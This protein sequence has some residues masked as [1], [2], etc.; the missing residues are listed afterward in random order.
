[1]TLRFEI[2]GFALLV[3]TGI[4]LVVLHRRRAEPAPAATLTT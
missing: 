3:A 1:M 4:L 2:V